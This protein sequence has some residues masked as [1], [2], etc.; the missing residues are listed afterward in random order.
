MATRQDAGLSVQLPNVY[1]DRRYSYKV[2]VHHVYVE[3][4]PTTRNNNIV[5]NELLC[6]NTNLVDRSSL[7]AMQTIF[8]F[9]NIAR[10]QYTQFA[11][12]PNVV[13][14]SLQLYELESATFEITRQFTDQLVDI[15][16]I[17]IQL[18]VLKIDAYG[19]V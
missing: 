5:D 11:K 10:K 15:K 6:L 9:W 7:N 8:H 14:Y 19:R 16:N 3:L 18:E 13:F 17:F 4:L 12:V 2:G 1:L